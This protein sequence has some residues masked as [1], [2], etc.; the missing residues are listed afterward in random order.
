M[1]LRAAC[2]ADH[3][4]GL[5]HGCNDSVSSYQNVLN[6][7]HQL[8]LVAKLDEPK[9]DALCSEEGWTLYRTSSSLNAS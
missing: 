1:F 4:H 7:A 2:G 8:L 6:L 9:Q 5:V 3:L